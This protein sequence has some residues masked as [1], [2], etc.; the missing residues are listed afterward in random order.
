MK[1]FLPANFK[2]ANGFLKVILRRTLSV[3]S[4]PTK[5]IQVKHPNKLFL[6]KKTQSNLDKN[7]RLLIAQSFVKVALKHQLGITTRNLAWTQSNFFN[8]QTTKCIS[9]SSCSKQKGYPFKTQLF[10]SECFQTK[11]SKTVR[12]SSL[13]RKT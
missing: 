13:T 1:C 10:Q 3:L 9:L 8:Y 4:A 5:L 11:Q 6:R 7:P 12:G 2:K